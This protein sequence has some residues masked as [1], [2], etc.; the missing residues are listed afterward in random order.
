MKYIRLK[1]YDV[2][3]IDDV[4]DPIEHQIKKMGEEMERAEN[5]LRSK[6]IN[7]S[8]PM[9]ER[10]IRL[11]SIINLTNFSATNSRERDDTITEAFNIMKKMTGFEWNKSGSFTYDGALDAFKKDVS[12]NRGR[13]KI[14]VNVNGRLKEMERGKT[15][16]NNLR[17]FF[18]NK[19]V[20]K[21]IY[22]FY[23][24][25]ENFYER[26]NRLFRNMRDPTMPRGRPYIS[27]ATEDGSYY[28]DELIRENI[29]NIFNNRGEWEKGSSRGIFR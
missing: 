1:K 14:G 11:E 7:D 13:M 25:A 6:I 23:D 16:W 17:R 9:L 20:H 5:V 26:L 3:L 21:M 10:M 19:K 29:S 15:N 4:F 27:Q 12:I 28:F 22:F 2:S 24:D 18:Y 8:I